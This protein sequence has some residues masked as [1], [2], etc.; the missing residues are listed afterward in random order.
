M[1]KLILIL[2]LVV[3]P[4]V[5]TA[6]LQVD[7]TQG[8]TG[9]LPIAVVPFGYSGGGQPQVDVAQVVETDLK[10]TGTFNPL[11]R[12]MM[13]ARPTAGGNVNYKNWRAVNVNNVVVGRIEPMGARVKV[14]FAVLDVYGGRQLAGYTITAG[15]ANLRNVAHRVADLVYEALTGRPG[16]FESKLAFVSVD[17]EADE[18]PY[19][20]MVSD[21]DGY[22]QR[23]VARSREPIMSARWSPDGKRLVFVTF[24]NAHTVVYVQNISTGAAS[25]VTD[26]PGLN[27]APTWSPDGEMLAL[28]LSFEGSPDIYLLDLDS[29]KLK[30]LT[31]SP[32]IDT[33]PDWSPD[34]SRV[35]FTSDRGGRPQLYMIDRE[36]GNPERLTFQGRSNAAGRFGPE[37]E[38][39]A[40]V[41][42][43]DEGYRI[44]TMNLDT[45][46]VSIISE[47]PLD[48]SPSI[49]PNGSMI[50]Y[51]TSAPRGKRLVIISADGQVTTPLDIPHGARE[52]AW[53]P[54]VHNTNSQ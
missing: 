37:G 45:G 17:R 41:R 3:S 24:E 34:G 40:M 25:K 30:R 15:A 49:A 6:A 28:S 27:S 13:L 47:G 9:G 50:V 10:R 4:G 48:E 35:L 2:V 19:K 12:N 5:S 53:S 21:Y 42:Q 44:A 38:S 32:A 36:G 22:N 31:S 11:P 1:R 23:V 20:L 29:G 33:E 16:A 8:I 46:A 18:Y 39:I 51:A 26:R 54:Y 52:P 14:S 43:G 7:I